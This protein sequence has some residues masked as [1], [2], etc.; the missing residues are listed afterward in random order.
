MRPSSMCAF[1]GYQCP[2]RSAEWL[3]QDRSSFRTGRTAA[4]VSRYVLTWPILCSPY[5][6]TVYHVSSDVPTNAVIIRPRIITHVH[7]SAEIDLGRYPPFS[8]RP[9]RLI[10]AAVLLWYGHTTRHRRKVYSY[11]PRSVRPA[12]FHSCPAGSGPPVHSWLSTGSL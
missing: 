2:F 4:D 11:Y 7:R 3:A 5:H 10:L 9:I 12:R 8:I 6:P 1:T